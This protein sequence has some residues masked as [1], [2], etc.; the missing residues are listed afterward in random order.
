MYL[1]CEVNCTGLTFCA[2]PLRPWW[3]VNTASLH[4]TTD[5]LQVNELAP[6]IIYSNEKYYHYKIFTASNTLLMLSCV[7]NFFNVCIYY[8]KQFPTLL[9]ECLPVHSTGKLSDVAMEGEMFDGRVSSLL[10]RLVPWLKGD[11]VDAL[12]MGSMM[13]TIGIKDN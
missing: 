13:T 2:Y 10:N 8:W 5:I 12:G 4:L 3:V 7:C 9:D 1:S 6:V 11:T